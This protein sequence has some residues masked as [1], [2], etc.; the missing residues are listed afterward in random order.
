MFIYQFDTN[1]ILTALDTVIEC[2]QMHY[3][4]I[5]VWTDRNIHIHTHIQ[6]CTHMHTTTH[7]YIHRHVNK[8]AHTQI[9]LTAL[10]CVRVR[11]NK[12]TGVYPPPP[13]HPLLA[14]PPPPS[15]AVVILVFDPSLL[16]LLPHAPS[17]SLLPTMRQKCE[18]IV[19]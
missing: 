14:P 3:M 8:H 9:S 19:S 4:Q 7:I 2:I 16:P 17:P 10:T 5:Y 12:C 6:I 13:H 15:C 11:T 1:D 18:A